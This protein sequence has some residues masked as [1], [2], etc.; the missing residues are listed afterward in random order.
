MEM[1]DCGVHIYF[2]GVTMRMFASL[3][4]GVSCSVI[5]AACAIMPSVP[6][7]YEFPIKEILRYTACELAIG[8]QDLYKRYPN[9]DASAYAI[10]VSMQPKLDREVTGNLGLTGKSSLTQS[11]FN[12]WTLGAFSAGGAPGAGIDVRG[13]QDGKVTY[14]VPS[15]KFVDPKH[16]IRLD[17][18]DW[19]PAYPTLVSNLGIRDWLYR[20][21]FASGGEMA[22][23]TS[24]DSQ[25]YTSEIYVL[26]RAGG[27]F[28][29]NFP[30]GTDFASLGGQQ[31]L[32]E[33]LTITITH[34]A[35]KIKVVTLP[36]GGTWE[37]KTSP[38]PVAATTFSPETDQK[39]LLL[40]LQQA[41]QNNQV[42]PPR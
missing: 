35:P 28:T 7:D 39:L 9:F 13:H 22:K 23:L 42:R 19:S 36:N 14:N 10:A 29:Y 33:F 41:I 37:L 4:T 3:V 2:V 12:S 20:S 15:A 17:C 34:V 31:Y 16:P 1:L 11:I 18:G 5:V 25:I 32:D 21:A 27:T 30:L 40:Q 24:V 38:V 6:T 26:Y 8:Y